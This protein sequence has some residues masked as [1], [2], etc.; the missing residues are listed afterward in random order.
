MRTKEVE[1]TKNEKLVF[2]DDVYGLTIAANISNEVSPT[3]YIYCL[4]QCVFVIIF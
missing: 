2:K 4:R 3:E 1:H